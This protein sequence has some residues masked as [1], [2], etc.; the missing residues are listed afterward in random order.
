MDRCQLF[1]IFE[2]LVSMLPGLAYLIDRKGIYRACNSQQA[3]LLGFESPNEIIG[4]S[5]DTLSSLAIYPEIINLINR[6][7]QKVF[8]CG[9]PEQFSEPIFTLNRQFFLANYYKIPIKIN[10]KV[11]GLIA[12]SFPGSRGQEYQKSEITLKHIIDNLPEH[13]YWK[14]IDGNYLGCNLM[15]AYDLNLKSPE[16][17]IGKTDYDLS[18]KDKADAFRAIDEKIFKEGKSIDTE[19][20]IEKKGQNV[21]VLSK[22]IPLYDDN[23][24]LIGLLGISFDISE[25]KKMEESL[26]KSQIAAE[27]ANQA[28]TEFIRNMEH[29]L[30]TPFSGMY[31]IVEYLARIET[32]PE[33]KELLEVT[34]QSA[35]E[36]LEL[37]NDILDFSRNQIESEP[38]LA[39]KFDLDKTLA[40]VINLEKP[41]ASLKQIQLNYLFPAK[42]P[43]IYMGDPRRVTRILINLLN[44]AIKF[45]EQGQVTVQVK[46]PRVQKK[47]CVVQLIVRDTGIGITEDKQAYIYQ[48]FYRLH[49]ANQN[50]YKGAGLGLYIVK[51]LLDDLDGEI[52]VESAPGKGSIFI[53]TLPLK[54]P[55]LDDFVD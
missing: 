2:S 49:P 31:S 44:N 42:I 8:E 36:F 51:E 48:K 39:K 5:N 34:Y 7:N 28:K 17:I 24:K 12:I 25:R 50:R 1:T 38:I 26:K 52:E 16:E 27:V 55:L 6:N 20:V 10:D 43:R 21:V 4:K 9:I 41:T 46:V 19:E 23:K 3:I 15:Q 54:R 11:I 22:K 35:E 14:G 30:R 37:L 32:D 53:C 18:P 29:Q 33:K 47:L 40:K 45:T 13:V